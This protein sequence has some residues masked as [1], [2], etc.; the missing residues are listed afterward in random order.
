MAIAITNVSPNRTIP[1]GLT[2]AGP[3]IYSGIVECVF[4]GDHPDADGV[5]RDTLTFNVGR[6]NLPSV[7]SP[8]VEA[9]CVVSLASIAYDGALNNALWA[10]DRAD[11]TQL[12]NIDRGSGTA[13]LEVVARLAVRGPTG[14]ILRVSYI[15]FF[16]R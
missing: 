3:R 1:S 8:P 9:S 5:T 16:P 4:R 7:T 2:S 10:V 11:V 15:V 12:V 14:L 6:V 13:D